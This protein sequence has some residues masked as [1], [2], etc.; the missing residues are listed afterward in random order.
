MKKM[1]RA[2]LFA[3]MAV[4]STAVFAEDEDPCAMPANLTEIEGVYQIGTCGDLYKFAEMVNGGETGI[5]GKLTAD[6]VVNEGVLTS[7][8]TL[9]GTNFRQWTPIG[10]SSTPYKGTFDGNAHVISGLYFSD[11]IVDYV[12]LF[13]YI[14][15]DAKVQ[16]VGV[17]DSYIRGET[18]VGGV[19]GYNEGTVSNVYNT[20]AVSGEDD[21]GGVVGQNLFGSVSNV[22][23]TGAVNG[24]I[25]VGG[26]VGDNGGTVSNVYNTGAVSGR[27]E[28]GG[29][30]GNNGGTISNVY[31]T[32]AVSGDK[33]IGGVVGK[34]GRTVSNVYNTGAVSGMY[35]VGGV[36]GF[37]SIGTVKNAY[38]NTDFYAGSALGEN[39]SGSIENVDGKT[40]AELAST[41]LPAGFSGEIWNA[42]SGEPVVRNGKLLLELPGLKD[43]GTQPEIEYTGFQPNAGG[44][45]EISN[46]QELK[47][48]AQLVNSGA[49]SINGRLT[50][51]ICLNA[52]G[53]GESVLKADGT[54]NGDGFN[55]TQWTP[56]GT[57]EKPYKGTFDG[58][59]KRISGLYFNDENVRYVGLFG[60]IGNGANVQN[61]GVV[62][63]YIR[64]WTF[65]GGVVGYNDGDL[66][67]VYN[68]GAVSGQGEVG[69]V[70]GWNSFDGTVRNVYN[71]G[72]VSG[73]SFVGGVVGRNWSF[74]GEVYNT[75]AVSG[76]KSVGG[77]VGYNKDFVENAYYN[78]DFYTGNAI[79]ENANEAN[80]S[81]VEGKTTAELIAIDLGP[82]WVAGNLAYDKKTGKLTAS[83]PYLEIFADFQ[84]KITALEFKVVD[85]VIQ[86]ANADDL[87]NFARLVSEFGVT[88]VDAELTA[89]ICVNACG[90]GESVLKADGS[91]NGDGFNFK[92]WT[93]IL[94]YDGTFDGN[95]YTI[96]G[97]YFNDKNAFYVGLFGYIGNG[98]YVQNVGVV[99][100]YVFGRNIVGGVV[101]YNLGGA[102][103]N[104][105][106]TGAVSG[107]DRV[108]GVVGLNEGGTISNVYNTGA[109]SGTDGVGGVVGFNA[110]GGTIS[111]AY[112]T[113]AVSG[114]D[115]VGGVVG[116]NEEASVENVYNTGAVSGED[117]VGGVVGN[118]GGGVVGLNEGISIS[119]AY[120]TGAVSG[121]SVV[122][123][124]VGNNRGGVV[125]LNEGASVENVYNTGAVS[126][127][128]VVGGVVGLN[129]GSTISNAYNTGVVSGGSVVGGVVGNN[130]GTVGNA[131]NT[132][133]VSGED[134]VGGVAGIND[135]TVRNGY[136]NTDML[137]EHCRHP[138]EGTNGKTTAELA[139]LDV[140]RA[141][142][143]SDGVWVAGYDSISN[144]WR[145]YAFPSLK[146]VGTAPTFIEL[147]P[148]ATEVEISNV[149]ELLKFAELVNAGN[150][151]LN[152]KLTADIVVN[153][154]VL[155]DDGTLNEADT[156]KFIK[157]TPI[158]T[159][160]NPYIGTF[161][162]QGH[163]VSGLYFNNDE[164]SNVGFFGAVGSDGET[165]GVV[166]NVG[167]VDSYFEGN[168]FVGGVVGL[169][170]E[171]ASV[172][173]VFNTGAVSGQVN[174]GGVVGVNGGGFVTNVYNTGSVSGEI[175]D[176]GGVIGLNVGEAR[177]VYS[178]GPVSGKFAVGGVVGLNEGGNVANA[179]YNSEVFEGDSIGGGNGTSENVEGKNSAELVAGT[180]LELDTA[181]W[182]LGGVGVGTTNDSLYYPYL[183]VFGPHK[184]E[185]SDVKKYAITVVVNDK[186]M[187]TVTG[188]GEYEYGTKVEIKAVANEGYK[189]TD[190]E[191]D[192]KT[193][194]RTITV[195]KAETYTANFEAIPSS[196]SEVESSSSAVESS[197]SEAK[198]SS[199]EA[200]SSSS[201]AKSSSSEAKSSSSSAKSSSSSSEAKSSS[202]EAKSSSS[203]AKSSSSEAESSSSEAKSSSSDAKSSSS[204][205]ESIIA[206]AQ[207]PQ[208][209]VTASGK[210]VS[211]AGARPNSIVNV[212]DMQGN[213]VKT[214]VAT[215]ANFTF[216]LPSAG[217]YIVKNGYTAKRVN[218][219]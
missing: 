100:S 132:G 32:G 89:D 219:R 78:T 49:T 207:L 53:E 202:S 213:R 148:N 191:D 19:V 88:D 160:V 164:M 188:A 22:Y 205:K 141:F 120:N 117:D 65:V 92:P 46:A 57:K 80:V 50:A 125:E 61:V 33:H 179:Y 119:N 16:N 126:G 41:T 161:D 60:Y 37:L 13:G 34:N 85:N 135:N 9:S 74:V 156:S 169:V 189:F 115:D 165:K 144:G 168:F 200:K 4:F 166:K 121:G 75:G 10:T 12:G 6:I 180:S 174:V 194:A 178:V 204:Q 52:C 42:G 68:T 133:A 83:F 193:A 43:V 198:S 23:N 48:F 206:Q 123:G 7:D 136:Y 176:V 155:N 138:I 127:G 81:H 38:C 142:E 17:V 18:T 72:A 143:N 154:N 59:G 128:S 137:C 150:A 108:G 184:Y 209:S 82:E 146:G 122:G 151:T 177:N 211:I 109:V 102:V 101:G 15:D 157:W 171:N 55:F 159:D 44:F 54:L 99:D 84:Y 208:F 167:V 124:V 104:V 158:G 170:M 36:V 163:T 210:M 94:A 95:G 106:N 26:V 107:T 145:K 98:A 197:S 215:A 185:L 140:A 217:V 129:D 28:V 192:V 97:L 45:Y 73:G 118:N 90:E 31:N 114:E 218:V 162:G 91:L 172:N 29:V 187:G 64:G 195:T 24:Q 67:N 112:N 113:G 51:D 116:H 69:G 186:A 103:S 216:A 201:D 25:G 214:V 212:F 63:S 39:K 196:S 30:V 130:R 131:Y 21:V 2:V 79:G 152:A 183:K 1:V 35:G 14:G 175:E 47:W 76:N 149:E 181:V 134:D 77:V 56:I 11:E 110:R 111:N 66:S 199:S 58:N 105:Y 173:A 71:T 40:T 27:G 203:E 62:D 3:M 96:S 139:A 153:E 190:W 20:G 86:I 8:G 87:K 93:P 182:V 147:D 70:V 5:N